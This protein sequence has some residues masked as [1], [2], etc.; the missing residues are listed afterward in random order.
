MYLEYKEP[1]TITENTTVLARTIDTEGKVIRLSSFTV[2]T[3]KKEE[4]KSTEPVENKEKEE[5]DDKTGSEVIKPDED[6]KEDEV[7]DNTTTSEPDT[8]EGEGNE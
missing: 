2:T 3:I 6:N 1:I 5:I 7:V 8:K 4:E